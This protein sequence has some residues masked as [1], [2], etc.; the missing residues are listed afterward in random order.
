[1]WRHLVRGVSAREKCPN[2]ILITLLEGEKGF[3]Q[4]VETFKDKYSR[5][6]INKYL[7]ELFESGLVTRKGRRGPYI[8]TRK[9]ED[10]AESIRADIML[11][12]ESRELSLQER[13]KLIEEI[14]RLKRLNR[15]YE[16]EGVYG[17]CLPL[18]AVIKKLVDEYGFKIEDFYDEHHFK[19]PEFKQM[20]KNFYLGKYDHFMSPDKLKNWTLLGS[21]YDEKEIGNVEIKLIPENKVHGFSVIDDKT[22]KKIKVLTQVE[23]NRKFGSGWVILSETPI[24]GCHIIGAYKELLQLYM[25]QF[26]DEWLK[27][28]EEFNLSDEDWKRVGPRVA[29]R[30]MFDEGRIDLPYEIE[31]ELYEYVQSLK[32]DGLE[33]LT[34]MYMRW[35]KRTEAEKL[36]KN[37]IEGHRKFRELPIEEI[38]KQYEEEVARLDNEQWKRTFQ[39]LKAKYGPR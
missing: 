30:M 29:F 6:T 2:D 16:L 8:L 18:L 23:V 25:E 28:K 4:I 3:E 27:W 22:E 31:G 11:L 13:G 10:E 26:E 21:P 24:K 39:Y 38:W 17:R 9:G 34:K 19:D 37:V 7:N 15:I 32:P 12:K 20:V 35:R 14:K 36:A 5:G 33:N 1:M